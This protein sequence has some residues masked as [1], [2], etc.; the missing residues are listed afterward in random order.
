[1]GQ[2]FLSAG[3]G[4][5][6]EYLTIDGH[7]DFYEKAVLLLLGDNCAAL[8]EGAHRSDGRN[9]KRTSATSL[10]RGI[11]REF[12]DSERRGSWKGRIRAVSPI[13]SHV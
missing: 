8:K 9:G 10:L 6:A 13:R 2:E 3:G 5:G 7:P 11:G 1:M 12:G 4:P